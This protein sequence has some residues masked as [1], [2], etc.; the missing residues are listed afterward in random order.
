[1]NTRTDVA[2]KSR[3]TLLTALI[4]VLHALPGCNPLDDPDEKAGATPSDTWTVVKAPAPRNV[5][6]MTLW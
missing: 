4:L 1:M 6:F 5:V 3:L 2:I